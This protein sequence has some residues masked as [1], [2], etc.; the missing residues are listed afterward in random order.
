MRSILSEKTLMAQKE[1]R[2]EIGRQMIIDIM[3]I[4]NQLNKVKWNMIKKKTNTMYSSTNHTSK[5]LSVVLK[6][7]KVGAFRKEN[8]KR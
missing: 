3:Y 7:D 1:K 2:L 8:N 5:S 4:D 6:V